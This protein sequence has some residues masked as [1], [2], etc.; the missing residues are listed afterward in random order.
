[1]MRFRHFCLAVVSLAIAQSA[2]GGEPPLEIR[3]PPLH[4]KAD[5]AV[6]VEVVGAQDLV[7]KPIALRKNEATVCEG[8]FEQ[9]GD[10]AVAK[11]SFDPLPWGIRPDV[12]DV[13]VDGDRQ[14][15]LTAPVVLIGMRG[16]PPQ[17]EVLAA[18]KAPGGLFPLIDRFGQ[19]RHRDWPGKTNSLDDLRRHREAEQKDL[20]EHPGP[21]GW[22]TYGGWLDGPQLEAT[23]F[24]RAQQHEGRWWLVDPDGSLFWSHG[25]DCVR[26]SSGYTPVTDRVHYFEPMPASGTPES[27]FLGQQTWAPKGYYERFQGRPFDTFNF[28]GVN[29]WRKYGPEWATAFGQ[30]AHARLLSWGLNSIGNW[31]DPDIYLLRKTP[32]VATCSTSGRDVRQIEG[33]TG[34]WGKFPD[35]FHAGFPA[36]LRRALEQEQGKAAGDPWCLGFFVH[37]ELGWGDE[38][39]LAAAALASPAD[40]PA[41][42]AMVDDLKSKY[43]TVEG[44]NAAW[45]TTHA[46]WNA[47]LADTT[48]PDKQK[49]SDDL[50]AFYT[51]LAEQYFRT[52]REEV[53]RAAP[54]QMYL[55]CRFAWVN[56]RAAKAAAEYCDVIAYNLYKRDIAEFR[57]PAGLDKPV[58]VGEFHFGAL[59]RGMFHPGLQKTANQQ[60]RAAMYKS[61][62][63]GALRNPAIVGTHWF[64][65]GDQATTGRGDGE[66]YQI[67]FLDI[68]DTPYPDTIAA[69]REVGE[70]MYAYRAQQKGKDE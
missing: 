32:Y 22:D 59:D 41:K 54:N 16:N 47:L 7:G 33:S 13:V 69:C 24:F 27:K 3:C 55:G 56:D 63:Q 10:R 34:Y 53:K 18:L 30:L 39:S 68:C 50:K 9:Q 66:N 5:Q 35:P 46:S 17:D 20:Q 36:S 11:L 28:T 48:L 2:L 70:T 51:R 38:T 12:L 31:S 37:N 62:V 19:Y 49:S 14:T 61:Y 8:R 21:K 43:G 26:S 23:G 1:M 6:V 58:I 57:L 40:Q 65:Y 42:L 15:Q 45:G 67:G 44:L 4:A 29:L 64:Q 52:C 60:E 25:I